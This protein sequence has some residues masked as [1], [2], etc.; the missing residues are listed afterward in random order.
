MTALVSCCLS[1]AGIRFLGIL[2]RPGLPPLLRSAY[3][4]ARGGTDPSGVSV[5]R[6]HELRLDR[7]P[8]IP[9]GRRCPHDRCMS[10]AAACRFTAASPCHPG[11]R[12]APGCVSHEASAKVHCRS[13]QPAFPSPVAPGGTR[14]SGFSLSFAPGR[15]GPCHAHQGGDGLW[16]LPGLRPWHQ[17][18]SFDVL[19]HCVRQRVATRPIR[20]QGPSWRCVSPGQGLIARF[21][22][23]RMIPPQSGRLDGTSSGW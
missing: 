23:K 17:P 20:A 8:S 7:V 5:F 15:A 6:T 13:P 4:A 2:S 1:A 14:P 18:A 16:A 10:P 22:Y 12:P 3:R 9:R 21:S 11:L 19:T